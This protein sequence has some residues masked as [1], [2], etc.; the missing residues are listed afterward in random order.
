[1]RLPAAL[2]AL[3]PLAFALAFAACGEKPEPPVAVDPCPG[4]SLVAFGHSYVQGNAPGAPAQPW[5]P[6][7]AKRLGVCSDNRGVSGSESKDTAGFVASYE[8][9]KQD[10]V[11][12]ETIINDVFVGGVR[13][14]PAYR[15]NLEKMLEHLTKDGDAPKRVAVLIDPPPAAWTGRPHQAPP[16]LHGSDGTLDRYADA[17]KDV[18]KKYDA[19]VVDLRRGWDPEHDELPDELHPDEA[20]TARIARLVTRAL[21]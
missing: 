7:V 15:A 11:A 17:T 3:L 19:T 8:P 9:A 5:A 10:M 12:I 16:Y 1:M 2:A 18:A 4:P 14:V 20:G 13:G 21:S 6:R